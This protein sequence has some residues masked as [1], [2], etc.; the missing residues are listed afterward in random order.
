M[1]PRQI[2]ETC[3][4]PIGKGIT[5]D[6]P[7]SIPSHLDTPNVLIIEQVGCASYCSESKVIKQQWCDRPSQH[8][9]DISWSQIRPD[10]M[11]FA[12][13]MEWKLRQKDHR[14]GWMGLD[15]FWL[16]KRLT[17]ES[18]ELSECLENSQHDPVVRN[19]EI[20]NEAVDVANFAMMIHANTTTLK[21]IEE[22]VS[23][24]AKK[25]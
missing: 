25:R 23:A 16:F 7:L 10:V 1:T 24:L 4:R 11:R 6:C 20:A 12:L 5:D 19:E 22:R 15:L 3:T 21:T 2:C 14:S 9:M 18:K 17:E 8:I 13:A